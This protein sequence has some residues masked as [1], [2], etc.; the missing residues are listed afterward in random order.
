MSILFEWGFYLW[1]LIA[2]PAPEQACQANRELAGKCFVVHGRLR[3]YNGNPV[4]RIWRIGTRRILGVTGAHPGEEPILPG[5]VACGFDCDVYG[6]FLVC[7]F[8]REQPGVMQRVC[9]ESVARRRE[10]RSAR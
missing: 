3:A 7:P 6:D 8:T 9:V 2:A 10:V 4:F 1:F 5:G